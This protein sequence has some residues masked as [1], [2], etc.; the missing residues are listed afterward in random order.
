M[1]KALLVVESPTKVRTL[2]KFLGKDFKIMATLGHIKDLPKSSLGV[3]I[4]DHF[5]PH[6]QTIRGRGKVI[7][8]IREAA[9]N[10]KSIYLGPDPDREGEAI[11]WH[12]AEEI[13]NG[14]REFKRVLFYEL[15][16]NAVKNAV[17]NPSELDENRYRS[18][19]ARRILDRLVGYLISP[20]LWEKVRRGLSAG[21]VQS[22]A[23][24]LICERERE[25]Q[26]FVPEEYW[27]ISAHLR[28]KEPPPF[29][30]KF[31]GKIG[32]K[33]ALKLKDKETVEKILKEIKGASF[34]VK[35][36]KEEKRQRRPL[37]PFI[38]ST[39]QQEAFRRL[40]FSAKKTMVLAQRLYEGVEIGPEGVIGL[41]TYMRTDSVRTAPE[42]I[43]GA[44]T[45]IKTY[46]G[47]QY[48][49][50]RPNK[51]KSP[52][53]AQEAHEAIRPTSI[54]RTPE[55]LKG[56]LEPDLLS[57]YTLIW[58]RFIASQMSPAIYNQTTVEIESGNYIFK[59]SGSR[60]VFD[61]FLKIYEDI[62]EESKEEVHFPEL[63]IGEK[64]ELDHIEPK[65]HFTKP[66]NRFTEASLVKELE[67]NGIGRPS[68][69]ATIISNIQERGY[70]KKESRYLV[71]TDL[72]FLITDL[73]VES[74]PRLMEV[75]FTA[76]MENYL[77]MIEEGKLDW[78]T[79]LADFY[80]GFSKDLE[81]AKKHMAQ[82][83]G[84][85]IKTEIKCE[86]CG[87]N[88]FIKLGKNGLF[89][90]C[91]R[92]PECKNTQNFIKTPDGEIK[93]IP[94]ER[95]TE[96]KCPNCGKELILRSG[97]Y[98]EFYACSGY[99]ECKYT[100]SIK[101]NNKKDIPV[102]VTEEKCPNCGK[103][104]LIKTN[105]YGRPFLACEDYPKCKTAKPIPTGVK[106]PLCDGDIVERFTR[107]GRP[108]YGCSNYPKCK[109]TSW[110]KPIPKSCPKC[111]S[112]Y[113]VEKYT[114]T[115]G[116]YIACPQKE[117]DYT[118]LK[119]NDETG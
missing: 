46:F 24:K 55:D 4:E 85:G 113:L 67:E 118:E 10:V 16:E 60:I 98:G 89:L 106:C 87:G 92:Y 73:L 42:A 97:R 33:K 102:K 103:N 29:V 1:A 40:R 76:E 34:I 86:L 56:F 93:I 47:E 12:V 116:H 66:P 45:F 90:A 8:E 17:K 72:G 2:N 19:I 83:K 41:I 110:Q 112:P 58:K 27:S 21:R 43:K 108:F 64:L 28:A 44:R 96:E 117:C 9:K 99:P 7:K 3:D 78:K 101:D 52:R 63:K 88:M 57:L 15:T 71:P 65:Q 13:G 5:K 37:P 79:L 111:N 82:I 31:Y 32:D 81:N 59:A 30:A 104:M 38:T 53:R 100:R 54:T 20:L 115:K 69:Y 26:A 49:P 61:G 62:S 80:K 75:K 119:E 94:K 51:F 107:K 48:L 50:S 114:K 91:E 77:D 25:I 22:V 18:Q 39:L 70:V 36:L 84:K 109:F 74:F 6:Y 95:P 11:A 105:R 14:K 35:G 23:V 68:T